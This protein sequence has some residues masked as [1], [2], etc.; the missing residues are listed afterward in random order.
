MDVG[1][2]AHRPNVPE[3]IL[4]DWMVAQFVTLLPRTYLSSTTFGHEFTSEALKGKI[5]FSTGIFING[6]S[7]GGSRGHSVE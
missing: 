1:R 7:F 3:L 4:N 6:E 5:S 2:L